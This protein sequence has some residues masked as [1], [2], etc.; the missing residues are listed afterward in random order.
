MDG[1]PLDV[2][3]MPLGLDV[4]GEPLPDKLGVSAGSMDLDGIPISGGGDG[5]DGMPSK[6][7]HNLQVQGCND[8]NGHK[9]YHDIT[10]S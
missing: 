1:T 4:D 2:D 8:Y 5:L 7:Y 3:G 6:G 10:C 9:H